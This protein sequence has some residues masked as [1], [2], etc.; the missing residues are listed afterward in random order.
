MFRTVRLSIIRSS[1][2]VHSAVV[3]HTG[4][5]RAG[6]SWSLSKAV[7]KPVCHVPLLSVQWMNSWWWTEELSETCRVSCQNKFVKLVHLVGFIVKKCVVTY[8]SCSIFYHASSVCT[9]WWEASPLYCGFVQPLVACCPFCSIIVLTVLLQTLLAHLVS[10]TKFQ[11]H[12]YHT[13]LHLHLPVILYLEV[14]GYHIRVLGMTMCK[15]IMILINTCAF[16]LFLNKISI[17]WYRAK[18]VKYCHIFELLTC[19]VRLS[20]L[21]SLETFKKYKSFELFVLTKTG[22]TGVV[23]TKSRAQWSAPLHC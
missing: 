10:G 19:C 5:F 9:D 7:Y 23:I 22:W 4:S 17:Y 6:P 3:C 18:I 11:T 16:Y 20:F 12:K 2:T 8:F 21:V 1:F 15:V 13:I 14:Q